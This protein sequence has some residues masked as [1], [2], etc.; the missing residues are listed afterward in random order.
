MKLFC[1][2]ALFLSEVG[3]DCDQTAVRNVAD[4]AILQQSAVE[5][6]SVPLKTERAAAEQAQ[7]GSSAESKS[8]P[9]PATPAIRNVTPTRA[10]TEMA[11]E[12]QAGS[13]L[14]SS[15]DCLAIKTFT[16][17]PYTHVAIVVLRRGQPYVYDSTARVGVRCQTLANYLR[18]LGP[19]PVAI[20][21]PVDS[22]IAERSDRLEEYLDGQLGRPYAVA[23]HVTGQRCEGVHCAEY[24]T[25][26]LISI[27]LVQAQRPP[28]VSPASLVSG[29]TKSG[30]YAS[31]T[32]WVVQE[33]PP[34]AVEQSWC[35]QC[36]QETKDCCGWSYRMM[37]G[38][39]LCH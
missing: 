21:Q 30:L 17:S 5:S 31:G 32:S 19:H 37:R 10:A 4:Q 25:E 20:F 14:V 9:R 16:G 34:P 27:Q 29:L 36:W 12:L 28:R 1:I 2:L 38:W 23:H 39:F 22:R 6:S 8:I 7:T 18:W 3:Q 24:L 35:S 11:P 26:A 15:G 33:P 13:L